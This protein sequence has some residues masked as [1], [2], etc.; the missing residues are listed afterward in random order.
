[1]RDVR[2]HPDKNQGDAKAAAQFIEVGAAF[3]VLSN[4]KARRDYDHR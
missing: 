1:M 4:E 2:F 3:Q